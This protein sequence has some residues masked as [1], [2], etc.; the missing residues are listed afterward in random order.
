MYGPLLSKWTSRLVGFGFGRITGW[1][2]GSHG[3]EPVLDF[4]FAEAGLDPNKRTSH[5]SMAESFGLQLI[6][7]HP[8]FEKALLFRRESLHLWPRASFVNLDLTGTPLPPFRLLDPPSWPTTSHP[9]SHESP[10]RAL[11]L[12]IA[13]LSSKLADPRSSPLSFALENERC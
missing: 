2:V 1:R 13:S 12:A 3:F 8:L 4:S 7:R 6:L 11:D 10:N 9:E 5:P